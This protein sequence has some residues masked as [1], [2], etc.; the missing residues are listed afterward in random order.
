[1]LAPHCNRLCVLR[2]SCHWLELLHTV[3]GCIRSL[4]VA[5][6]ERP[7]SNI[8]CVQRLRILWNVL[9]TIDLRSSVIDILSTLQICISSGN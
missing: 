3:A 5:C 2:A 4:Y 6:N 7:V 9:G 8:P 1:M